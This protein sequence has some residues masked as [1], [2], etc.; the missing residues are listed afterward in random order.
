[1]GRADRRALAKL[2]R[3]AGALCARAGTTLPALVFVLDDRIA[4]PLPA[5]QALPRGSLV[6]LRSR[7]RARRL[8][9]ARQVARLARERKLYW[10]VAD[11]PDLAHTAGAHGAHFPEARMA[12]AFRWRARRPGWLITC[13]AHSLGACLRA[14][15]SGANAALL[16]P[17]FA[18]K[19]H[20]DRQPL[21]TV[22]VRAIA[23]QSPLPV[24]ALGGI[25]AD[26]A[27]RLRNAPL[28]GIAAVGALS[29]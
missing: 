15:R 17:A 3:L 2:S 24:Y 26:N 16:A 11:D 13:A 23:R 5:I 12:D 25:D 20:V 10:L 8:M 9:L 22:R 14:G 19:S 29:R 27:E 28:A 18:T 6:I 21:G 4:D 1:M 7:E